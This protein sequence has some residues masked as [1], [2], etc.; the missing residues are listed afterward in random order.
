[1]PVKVKPQSRIVADNSKFPA[2][3]PLTI[4]WDC[5]SSTCPS[6]HIPLTT[7]N[8]PRIEVFNSISRPQTRH[9]FINNI[10]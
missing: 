4:G 7:N 10:S 8:V 6:G 2:A 5:Q 1:M 3:I 9:H